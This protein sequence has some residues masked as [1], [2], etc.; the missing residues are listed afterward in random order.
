MIIIISTNLIEPPT[1]SLSFRNVTFVTKQL[2]FD[3]LIEAS[4]WEFIDSY[5]YYSKKMGLLDYV[6]QFIKEN[7]EFGLRLDNDH[8]YSN[9]IKIPYIRIENEK[10]ILGQI[11]YSSYL[12][13]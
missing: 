3:N 8:N 12:L 7:E 4:D 2:G 1:E 9:T 5:Y 10:R 6:E 13:T 11:K